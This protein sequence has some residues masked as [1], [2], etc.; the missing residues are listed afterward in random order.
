MTVSA[1]TNRIVYTGAGLT[2]PFAI[3]YYFL[4][5][6]DLKVVK[7][8]IA[9]PYT[10]TTLV[11]NT[12]YTL[13]GAGVIAGGGTLNLT[14]AHGALQATH[15]LSIIRD[16]DSLQGLDLQPNDPFPAD[17]VERSL[18]KLSMRDQRFNDLLARSLKLSDGDTSGIGGTLPSP[19]ASAVLAINAARTAFVW[20]LQA[21][22]LAV[23]AFGQTLLNA[24][25]AAAARSLLG[26]G[27]WCGTAGGTANAITL[28]PAS[29]VT[30]INTGDFFVW[31][32]GAAG[33][34]AATTLNISGLG[35][36]PAQSNGAAMVGGEI[37][38]NK[39]YSSLWDGAAFQ[40]T[41]LGHDLSLPSGTVDGRV[42]VRSAA[43][44]F[45][46]EYVDGFQRKNPIINGAFRINQRLPATNA[47]DTYA[48][49]CWYALTQTNPIALTTVADAENGTP[50]MA[51]LTQSNAVAQRMGY[52]QII[53][54]KD[55]R[56]LRGKQVTFRFGR[57]RISNSQ[58]IRYAVL[59]WTGAEDAVVS[60][61][62]NDWTSADYTDGAA[63]F[64]V[65]A[66]FTPLGNTSHTPAAATLTDGASLSVNVSGNAVNLVVF[67]WTEGTAAQNVTLDLAKAQIEIG[68]FATEFERVHLNADLS[69][70]QRFY[71]K[72][73]PMATAPAQNA[74]VA[75]AITARVPVG[76]AGFVLD[77]PWHFP[78]RMRAAP[79][80]TTYNPSAANANWRNI[81]AGADNVVTVD[82][83]TEY[84]TYLSNAGATAQDMLK[85]HATA[86]ASL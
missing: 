49:D 67:A 78:I 66:N 4:E 70:C 14:A 58:P 81:T 55:C 38:A 40:T 41:R 56:H 86:D 79:T 37:E 45:G 18:D 44:P 83:T 47:D 63:K 51:R 17:S 12:D 32:S 84:A 82:Q 15:N 34:N 74:G 80:L 76:G 3:P 24:A 33:N 65:D 22:L 28:T 36:Q 42:L 25:S 39:W 61:I 27:V 53:E 7:T 52:A 68:S 85:I 54:G 19:V 26:N 57:V 62:V 72:T 16:P 48:H 9:A 60:D 30:A 11:L 75:G 31:K 29:A 13:T 1:E 73:F 23:S 59:E 69:D 77:Q 2:G 43:Q 71:A 64:F 46:A 10:E 5:D 6:D 50:Y 20:A 21:G 8:L 35:A